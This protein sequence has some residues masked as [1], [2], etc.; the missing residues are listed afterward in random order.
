L[1]IGDRITVKE[2]ARELLA[3]ANGIE[4]ILLP[5]L[6]HPKQEMRIG[7]ASWLTE[8]KAVSSLKEIIA[9]AKKEKLP[10]A[11]AALIGAIANLGGDITPFVSSTA[12]VTEAREGLKKISGKELVW[13][14][15]DALPIPILV[16]G[17]RLDP[18][19]LR[20]WLALAAKLKQPGGSPWFDLLL[21]Q[22]TPASAASI[23][24]AVLQ[25]WIAF[26]TARPSEALANAHAQA[27]VQA[28]LASWKRWQPD[29]THDSIFAMLRRQKL[30]EYFNSGN[31][32]KGILA[33]AVRVPGSEAVAIVRTYFRDH[34][35]RTAQCK[36]LLECLA[37]NPSAVAT[38]YVLSIAKRWRTRTVQETASELVQQIAAK[39]GWTAE[40]LADRTI[41]TAGFDDSGV[42]T[43][44]GGERAYTVRLDER[45]QFVLFNP[46]GK[47]VQGLPAAPA[48]EKNSPLGEAKATLSTA[49]KETKQ[50]FEFQA[51]RLYE[52]LC[53]ERQ[54][55]RAEWSE[56]LLHHPLM[57]RLVQRLLWAG[58]D[59]AG[60]MTGLFR[61]M[62]DLSLTGAA[63][64]PIDMD[65]FTTIRLAHRTHLDA[66]QAAS[67]QAH[68]KD[69]GVAP[70]FDQLGRA[71]LLLNDA[72]LKEEQLTDRRGWLIQAFKL[73][74]AATKLGYTRGAAEDGGV[75]M[76]YEKSFEAL[77]LNAVVEFTGNALPEEDR[78][79]ALTGLSFRRMGRLGRGGGPATLKDVPGV[80]LSEV[81]NDFHDIAATGSGYDSDWEKK[82]GW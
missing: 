30:G 42:L 24:S 43:L 73:R 74:A 6:S 37:G 59:E 21:A 25:A 17:S 40:E 64:E 41:P 67:W 2:P 33:L 51:K 45:N 29:A 38:Q 48:G 79:T 11:K 1:A 66:Q 70:L 26:D 44:P 27:N 12:L 5:L 35:P 36:A 71:P 78:L 16:D 22:L 75:F 3:E 77:Q 47:Q 7:A 61:P 28:T 65:K 80:L 34:Y 18:I 52:A 56:F 31:D 15:F 72:L 82:A 23:G 49:R 14:P 54:W 81:W 55:P 60:T 8:R 69:Y 62:E 4:A 50:V 63:D 13:F 9:A 76:T 57:G 10:S 53:V 20:W 19:V 32:S 39:R 46:D 68:F 58:L